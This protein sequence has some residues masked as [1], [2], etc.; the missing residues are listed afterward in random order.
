MNN[1]F[2]LLK[3]Q[4]F[5]PFFV[6]QALGAFND[7]IFKNALLLFIA[8]TLANNPQKSALLNNLAAGLFILPFFFFSA[9]AGQVADKYPK[10]RLIQL[11]K[12]TE[13]VIAIAACWAFHQQNLWALLL[14]LF[15]MGSQ[16]AFFGP[17]KFSILP[18]QLKPS[19]LLAGNAL[20]EM[21]TF[22]AILGGT[23]LAA[24]IF[25]A[26]QVVFWISL[27]LV[28]FALFGL[29]ASFFIPYAQADHPQHRLQ[30]HPIR[31]FKTNIA[32]AKTNPSITL[33][34]IAISWFWFI[35]AT[36]LTQIPVISQQYVSEHPQWVSVLLAS[37]VVGIAL[38]SLCCHWLL[39]GAITPKLVLPS[40]VAISIILM[41]AVR[42]LSTMPALAKSPTLSMLDTLSQWPQLNLIIDLTALAFFAGLFVVPLQAMLQHHSP[43]HLRAQIIGCN[44]VFNALFM[45][46]SAVI[47]MV[48]LG[49][50][51]LATPVLL[52]M[53]AIINLVVLL[54][55]FASIKRRQTIANEGVNSSSQ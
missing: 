11:L 32:L 29:M 7:N 25:G 16:S 18:Q 45:V 38:G 50:L 27:S 1:Q 24:I 28:V 53:T 19:E 51:G 5:L 9:L 54:W 6:T 15:L 33:A 31:A 37:F 35:G 52:G 26:N 4:R 22:V 20:V 39:N 3:Q 30:F 48:V 36:I 23:I 10:H 49:V 43:V 46:M 42:V 2:S 17:V 40:G 41:D 8:F 34:I 13:L 55:C 12:V 47:A 14:L 44:N 21:G